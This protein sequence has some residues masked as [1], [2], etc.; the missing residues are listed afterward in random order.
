MDVFKSQFNHVYVVVTPC[1]NYKSGP[2]THYKVSA[3]KERRHEV[4]IAFEQVEV[5]TKNLKRFLPNVP[6]SG[7]IPADKIREWML[8]KLV[9]A[10]ATAMRSKDFRLKMK[11]TRVQTL[12]R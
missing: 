7:L 1:S 6:E 9:N 5:V 11:R 4:V 8:L 10:E 2:A 3:L 12:E